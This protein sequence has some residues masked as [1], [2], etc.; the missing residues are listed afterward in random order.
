MWETQVQSLGW[1]DPLEKGMSTHSSILAWKIP[2]TGGAWWATVHK[3]AKSQTWLSNYQF[4]FSF[5]PAASLS[6]L[7]MIAK[8]QSFWMFMEEK[9]CVWF[10]LSSV[11]Y[12]KSIHTTVKWARFP[13]TCVEKGPEKSSYP[14]YITFWKTRAVDLR[15][16]SSIWAFQLLMYCS[17]YTTL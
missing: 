17:S 13:Q 6:F 14:Q 11:N 10:G 1:K 3:V 7:R 2:W 15:S 9:K 4:H 16:L 12:F 8:H 5:T